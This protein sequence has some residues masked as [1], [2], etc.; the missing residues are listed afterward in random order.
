MIRIS[1]SGHR[2]AVRQPPPRRPLRLAPTIGLAVLVLGVHLAG[3][4][5]QNQANQTPEQLLSEMVQEVHDTFPQVATISTEELAQWLADPH[6]DPPQ[7][8]DVREKEEYSV[9]HLPGALRVDPEADAAVLAATLDPNRPVILYCSVGY[10]SSALALRL[11]T[12]MRQAPRNL[13]GSIFKWAN[14][15]R[16]LVN[17]S[18][19]TQ[20]VHTYNNHFGNMVKPNLHQTP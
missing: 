7:L 15:G 5:A 17:T 18:G 2:A 8:L 9:S 19:Q 6:R 14:E 3:C 11:S 12:A 16:P 20:T 13:A 10:R 4:Q 1:P